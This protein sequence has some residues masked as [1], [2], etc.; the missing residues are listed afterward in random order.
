MAR[1]CSAASGLVRCERSASR[2]P[3]AG[4]A[5]ARWSR[6][7]SG[8]RSSGVSLEVARADGCA[9]GDGQRWP[10]TSFLHK[11]GGRIGGVLSGLCVGGRG[12]R[13]R[14][15]IRRASLGS[16]APKAPPGS[17]SSSS[18]WRTPRTA[19]PRRRP[20]RPRRGSPTG[21]SPARSSSQPRRPPR[22]APPARLRGRV[23]RGRSG[24]CLRGSG[25]RAHLC[26]PGRKTNRGCS[27]FSC[28]GDR[29]QAQEIR[30]ERRRQARH[31]QKPRL[32]AESCRIG[33]S[34]NWAFPA[35]IST[36]IGPSLP[37]SC[38]ERQE[39]GH[40]GRRVVQLRKGCPAVVSLR[41]EVTRVTRPLVAVRRII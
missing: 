31:G 36:N 33:R 1:R 20:R 28:W 35:W 32:Q 38:G 25:R 30:E 23:G 21:A 29:G 40:Y 27:G 34:A 13:S 18:A 4:R 19:S 6:S 22:Q 26:G 11:H 41:F 5:V 39:M 8:V 2:W 7:A 9:T 24:C 3:P 10:T 16:R 37:R 17:G 14:S 15:E 12:G